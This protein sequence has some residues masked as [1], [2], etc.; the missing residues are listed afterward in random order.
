MTQ[1]S[2]ET[3]FKVGK[4]AGVTLHTE[5]SD[6]VDLNDRWLH[7]ASVNRVRRRGKVMVWNTDKQLRAKRAWKSV[8]EQV[9]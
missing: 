3:V 6:K 2:G 5:C 4:V 9:R 7:T 1:C 8:A